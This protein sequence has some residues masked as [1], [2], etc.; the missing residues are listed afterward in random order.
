MVKDTQ[1][2]LDTRTPSCSQSGSFL[3]TRRR[4]RMSSTREEAVVAAE[5]VPEEE[6][7]VPEAQV[8]E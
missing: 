1:A 5:V 8:E 2:V 6:E 4:A 3:A 7:V